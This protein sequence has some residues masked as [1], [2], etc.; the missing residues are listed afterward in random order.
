MTKVEWRFNSS[1][2]IILTP[3]DSKDKQLAQLC[4]NGRPRLRLVATAGDEIVIEATEAEKDAEKPEAPNNERPL[5]C[6]DCGTKQSAH[7]REYDLDCNCGG[8]FRRGAL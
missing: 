3:E 4:L 8:T 1:H 2:R 7:Q 6:D 5:V